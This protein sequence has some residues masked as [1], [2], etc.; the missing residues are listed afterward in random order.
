MTPEPASSATSEDE[1][2]GHQHVV[3]KNQL[4]CFSLQKNESESVSPAEFDWGNF[5]L[6]NPL[7]E[8]NGK[9]YFP[10]ISPL[11]Q[12]R[13]SLTTSSCSGTHSLSLLDIEFFTNNI[14]LESYSSPK[15]SKFV[16]IFMTCV[17]ITFRCVSLLN[18]AFLFCFQCNN[19]YT[20][21]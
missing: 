4:K 13:I 9:L 7:A 1:K 8:E 10:L 18:N 6:T 2:V 14:K 21:S 3:M 17:Y 5:G 11:L 15:H 20:F 16:S 12:P 19:C